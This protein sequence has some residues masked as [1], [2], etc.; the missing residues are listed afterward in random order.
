M[1]ASDFKQ[2]KEQLVLRFLLDQADKFE[3]E[4]KDSKKRASCMSIEQK[5]QKLTHQLVF[6]NEPL[7]S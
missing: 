7:S 4:G 6:D 1:P 3:D 5:S 2:Y